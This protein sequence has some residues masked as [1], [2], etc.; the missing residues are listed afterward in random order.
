MGNRDAINAKIRRGHRGNSAAVSGYLAGQVAMRLPDETK[1]KAR[2]IAP[3]LYSLWPEAALDL[4]G[5]L[6]LAS[7]QSPAVEIADACHSGEE[8]SSFMGTPGVR[9]IGGNGT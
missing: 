2:Y 7:G 6:A 9:D 4:V 5:S 8:S 3:A 1:S